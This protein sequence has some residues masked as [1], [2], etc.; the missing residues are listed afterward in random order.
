MNPLAGHTREATRAASGNSFSSTTRGANRGQRVGQRRKS[1]AHWRSAPRK[2]QHTSTASGGNSFNRRTSRAHWWAALRNIA[3]Y[4]GS[5]SGGGGRDDA[6][7]FVCQFVF[8]LFCN[9]FVYVLAT[10]RVNGWN[11]HNVHAVDFLGRLRHDVLF[12]VHSN[13]KNS[14]FST[15]VMF[16]VLVW[17]LARTS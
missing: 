12:R 1:W 13:L 2:Q 7:S 10:L 15:C 3:K 11:S 5:R 17:G 6:H 4:G 16:H 8:Y 9:S 14:V